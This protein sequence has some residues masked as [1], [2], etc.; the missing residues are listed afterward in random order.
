MPIVAPVLPSQVMGPAPMSLARGVIDAVFC[1]MGCLAE[2]GRAK[3]TLRAVRGAARPEQGQ[4]L[5]ADALPPVVA[6]VLEP[7]EPEAMR[8]RLKQLR[9]PPGRAGLDKDDWRGPLGVFGLVFLSTFPV[10]IPFILMHDAVP[11]LRVSNA[12]AVVLP[13]LAGRAFGR[14]TGRSPAWV[15]AAMVVLGSILW[16]SRSR[17]GDE[18]FLSRVG[19]TEG[20]AHEGNHRRAEEA[21]PC[22]LRGR[23]RAGRARR[24]G[25]SARSWASTGGPPRARPRNAG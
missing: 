6:S 19:W 13:F 22:A 9:E 3:L 7:A 8:M 25:R 21:G 16:A 14:I 20:H 5:L 11:A 23:S 4:R 12:I 18:P 1:L 10:V 24:L 2:K 17:W 15:G